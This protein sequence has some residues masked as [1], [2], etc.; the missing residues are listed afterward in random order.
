MLHSSDT[1]E[2]GEYNGTGLYGFIDF[3]RGGPIA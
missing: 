3:R 2:N 1:G